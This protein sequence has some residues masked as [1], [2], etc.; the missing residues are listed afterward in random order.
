MRNTTR[1]GRVTRGSSGVAAGV[2]VVSVL[3]TAAYMAV[4]ASVLWLVWS[5]IPGALHLP[6]WAAWGLVCVVDLVVHPPK[7]QW[8][9]R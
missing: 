8:G 9:V 4:M 2:V 7:L 5:N 6:W 3:F 1:Q